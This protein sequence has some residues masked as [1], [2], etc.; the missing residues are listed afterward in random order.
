[1]KKFIV[2]VYLVAV[3][4]L[5]QEKFPLPNAYSLEENKEVVLKDKLNKVTLIDLWATWCQ[6]CIKESP[7]V[8]EIA[9]KFSDQLD[10]F[11]ISLDQDKE[12]WKTYLKKKKSK[13]NH[14]IVPMDSEIITYISEVFEEN[15]K[16]VV[17]WSIPRF[18]LINKEG[19]TL[20]KFGPPSSSG[21]L[22]EM[23][24]GYL[25]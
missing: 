8:E 1:M 23:I 14:F 24:V 13:N 17:G 10:V 11:Y 3:S 22:E 7:Y 25:Q 5:A 18:I 19:T 12:K 2:I 6:P 4:G 15:G 16:E 21:L 9:T 20:I